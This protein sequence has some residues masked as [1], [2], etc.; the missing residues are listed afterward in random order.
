MVQNRNRYLKKDY[1]PRL[2]YQ[3]SFLWTGD[4]YIYK[5]RE[6]CSGEMPVKGIGGRNNY[7]YTASRNGK[8]PRHY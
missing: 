3:G 6:P 5:K 8:K 4:G 7:E 2:L 1:F